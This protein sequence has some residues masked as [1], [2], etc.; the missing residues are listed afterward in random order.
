MNTFADEADIHDLHTT[1]VRFSGDVLLKPGT[2]RFAEEKSEH[3][4]EDRN[5]NQPDTPKGGFC[6]SKRH[7]GKGPR[8]KRSGCHV[9]AASGVDGEATFAREQP[10]HRLRR[11][12]GNILRDH[13]TEQEKARRVGMPRHGGLIFACKDVKR[14]M[15]ERVISSC[16]ED[17]GKIE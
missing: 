14:G 12:G 3:G 4:E 8:E 7:P 2:E 10:R 11:G 9:G 17:E 5:R 6:P 15:F 13:V 1:Q 16:F